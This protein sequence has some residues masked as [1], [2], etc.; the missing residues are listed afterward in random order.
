MRV[1][2]PRAYPIS[3]SLQVVRRI[4]LYAAPIALALAC[5]H[6]AEPPPEVIHLDPPPKGDIDAA[7]PTHEPFTVIDIGP[8]DGKCPQPIHP[9]YCN[10]RCRGYPERESS[11]HAQRIADPKRWALGTCGTF[12]AFA[13]EEK[14]GGA[15]LELF[16]GDGLIASQ[17]TRAEGCK[18]FF[19]N[20]RKDAVHCTVALTWHDA[21][22]EGH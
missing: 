13:E 9:G 15:I 10:F 21:H 8:G 18:T 20:D 5:H 6:E 17:D 11:H 2:I 3:D 12:K 7:P 16:E 14:D 19:M 22:E 1:T 4:A